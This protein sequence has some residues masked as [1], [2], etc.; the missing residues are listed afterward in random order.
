MSSC[1]KNCH[2]TS[3]QEL[4]FFHYF[5][6]LKNKQIDC[7][8]KTLKQLFVII[9]F[10]TIFFLEFLRIPSVICKRSQIAKFIHSRYGSLQSSKV[11][12]QEKNISIQTSRTATVS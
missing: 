8:S 5:S 6:C 9:A 1:C 12:V 11:W 4:S 3:P 7:L 10:V 2:I